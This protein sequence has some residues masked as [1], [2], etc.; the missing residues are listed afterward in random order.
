MKKLE[1]DFLC[2]A[3][4]FHSPLLDWSGRAYGSNTW[5]TASEEWKLSVQTLDAFE[6]TVFVWLALKGT[7]TVPC[8]GEKGLSTAAQDVSLG[9][10]KVKEEVVAPWVFNGGLSH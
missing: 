1:S 7:T 3:V 6:G 2:V 8:D 5:D 4:E 10:E 9:D